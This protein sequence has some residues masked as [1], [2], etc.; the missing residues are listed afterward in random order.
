M[1]KA[2]P[3]LDIQE[4]P[5]LP[6]VATEEQPGI[7]NPVESL[8]GTKLRYHVKR[9][10]TT[11]FKML[12]Y[13]LTSSPVI[14]V[15]EEPKTEPAPDTSAR[16]GPE[17][18][19]K[20]VMEKP[21]KPAPER[22]SKTSPKSAASDILTKHGSE[23]PTKSPPPPPPRKTFSSS[24]S[25]MTTTRSGEVVFINRKES[26]SSQVSLQCVNTTQNKN[27]LKCCPA[28][29]PFRTFK[30]RMLFKIPLTSILTIVCVPI[31]SINFPK[32]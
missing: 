30:G 14:F 31:L 27:T 12:Y 20:P 13:H 5:A 24:T 17:K 19:P 6:P 22:P 25:G 2:I 1:M 29:L 10:K 11:H 3:S 9:T 21:A 7:N 16:K 32:N 8:S 15:T 23:K 4:N 18:L 28:S 26:V